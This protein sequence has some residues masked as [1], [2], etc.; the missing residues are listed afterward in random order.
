M[1][2]SNCNE[3]A[4]VN[5]SLSID[6]KK[7]ECRFTIQYH[8]SLTHDYIRETYEDFKTACEYFHQYSNIV[9]TV[10]EL[11]KMHEEKEIVK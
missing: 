2:S 10:Y 11:K 9:D 4:S 6:W 1:L 7:E 8:N 5:L 3:Y